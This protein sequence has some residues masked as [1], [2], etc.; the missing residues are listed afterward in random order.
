[1]SMTRRDVLASSAAVA[2]LAAGG[3][4]F[5]KGAQ[6][7]ARVSQIVN[8]AEVMRPDGSSRPLKRGDKVA[9]GET[10]VT[11]DRAAVKLKLSDGSTVSVG[12]KGR[13]AVSENKVPKLGQSGVRAPAVQMA[14]GNFRVKS[15]GPGK[16][17]AQI[18]TPALRIAM[19]GTEIVVQ[20]ADGKTGCGV[21][22]GA[23]DCT[24]E[25]TG[26]TVSVDA[27]ENVTWG[28]GAFSEVAEGPLETG[29]PSIDQGFEEA[30][31]EWDVESDL[32]DGEELPEEE[33]EG[34]DGEAEPEPEP[35]PEAEPEAEPEVDPDAPADMPV[36]DMP[37]EDMPE[38]PPDIP[39][40]VPPDLPPEVP[41]D[42]GG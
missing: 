1:M 29:D 9:A 17:T 16:T 30:A 26:A 41:E 21:V 5:A 11:P 38:L 3:A 2:A 34:T 23:I 6:S 40:D 8:K 28:D 39:P 25:K 7:P 32:G 18:G 42:P 14:A 24:S 36:E 33:T 12:S 10:V 15:A 4:A 22:S 35:E 20:I 19:K 13:A 31:S 27:G 37:P